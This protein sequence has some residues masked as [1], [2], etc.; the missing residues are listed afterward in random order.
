MISARRTAWIV[1]VLT[2]ACVGLIVRHGHSGGA[3]PN[4]LER[5]R[6]N[7]S[8]SGINTTRSIPSELAAT[9][10]PRDPRQSLQQGSLRDTVIDGEVNVG[11]AG[12]LEPDLALRRLF[13]YYLALS[14]ET[15][16][17]S[18]R[19]LLQQDLLH[20][21]LAAS[22]ADEVMETFEN[23]VRYQQAA[24]DLATQRGIDLNEQ[25]SRL[26]ILRQQIL[27]DS[28]A[29]AFY[30]AEEARQAIQ[31]QRLAI[32]SR[33]DLSPAQ[34]SLQLQLLDATVPAAQREARAEASVGH[35]VQQ[36]TAQF[37]AANADAATRHAER[38]QIW[39]STV[40][41]RL[42]LLDHQRAQ[43]QARLDVYSSER[44]RIQHNEKLDMA[45]RQTALR[46]L[47]Q[48]SFKDTEQLQV[49]AM[50][51]SGVLHAAAR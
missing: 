37:D 45:T 17:S 8:F 10:L 34:R 9:S 31:M 1:A 40:A 23:Y 16:L 38:A 18:I 7:A 3:L 35:L 21:K 49:Q 13:D 15:D 30:G 33:N 39:G 32:E 36:Q 24:T 22:L 44:E 47:L 12:R 48:T 42:A 11:F 5:T 20:R 29:Q 51:R 43:W 2:V 46:E 26:H 14:G 19:G 50:T 41:D 25:F 27:G 4:R 6:H 28:V